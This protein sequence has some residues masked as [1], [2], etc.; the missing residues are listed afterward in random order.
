MQKKEPKY[1]VKLTQSPRDSVLK[2]EFSCTVK[3]NGTFDA[4]V[5]F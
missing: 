3:I 2:E 4:N 5:S 1:P